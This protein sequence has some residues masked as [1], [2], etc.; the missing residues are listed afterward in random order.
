MKFKTL[1][2]TL[3]A[4]ILMICM[5]F[6]SASASVALHDNDVGWHCQ[7]DSPEMAQNLTQCYPDFFMVPDSPTS[8]SFQYGGANTESAPVDA[9]T[10]FS[11]NKTW[12][13]ADTKARLESTASVSLFVAKTVTPSSSL[14]FG[15]G[16]KRLIS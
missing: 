7:F 6:G 10:T 8:K 4:L 14:K 11:P 13:G 5:S 2:T 16:T 12:V 15:K 9:T 1:I 3:T